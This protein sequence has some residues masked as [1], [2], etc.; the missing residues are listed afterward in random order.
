MAV[1]TS[2]LRCPFRNRAAA[3]RTRLGRLDKIAGLEVLH[4]MDY[5]TRHDGP[6]HLG[7]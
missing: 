7:L 3:E 4:N 6:D 1:I 5:I 2:D